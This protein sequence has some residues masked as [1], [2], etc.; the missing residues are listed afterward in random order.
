V[1]LPDGS[2][3]SRLVLVADFDPAAVT[4]ALASI[5]RGT[6]SER[7]RTLV[8]LVIDDGQSKRIATAAQVAALA[9][10]VDRAR[11]R[12]IDTVFPQMDARD[13]AAI[14]A[15]TLWSGAP[16][17]ALAAASRYANTA[18]V[19]RLR[20]D[21]ASWHGAFALLDGGPPAQWTA[22][23]ADAATLLAWAA[24]GL[25]DRLAQRYTIA[26]ADRVVGDYRVWLTDLRSAADFADAVAYLG[27]LS[28]VD[29]LTPEGAD[30]QRLLVK[31]RLNVRLE[32][33]RDVLGLGDVMVWD[34][35]GASDGAQATFRLRH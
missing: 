26:P 2:A 14:D 19:A 31:L 4:R 25:A 9:S 7:P 32:K 8:W 28:L 5:G 35:A 20:R 33:M 10:F 34:D 15:E 17:A 1:N 29:A 13:A 23:N 30:G 24:A 12:G 3:G 16:S 11:E 6:W 21:G 22:E 27:R 18:L